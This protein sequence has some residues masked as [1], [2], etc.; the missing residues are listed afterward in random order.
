MQLTGFLRVDGFQINR[1]SVWNL[2]IV[3]GETPAK[4]TLDPLTD[5]GRLC[6]TL[7]MLGIWAW[8]IN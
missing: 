1:G 4:L 3:S 6:R 2:Q 7:S 5:G 8:P